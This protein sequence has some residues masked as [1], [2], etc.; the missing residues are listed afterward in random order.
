MEDTLQARVC[1]FLDVRSGLSARVWLDL[2]SDLCRAHTA[3]V[4]VRL[5]GPVSAETDGVPLRLG[6]RKQRAVFALLALQVNSPVAL[7]RLVDELWHDEPPAQATLSLQSYISRLRRTISDTQPEDQSKDQPAPRILTRPPGWV[8]IMPAENVDAVRF[9]DLAREGSAL[10]EGADVASGAAKLREGLALWTG[11]ALADLDDMPFAVAEKARLQDLRVSATESLLWAELDLGRPAEVV[12]MARHAVSENPYREHAWCALMLALYRLGRQSEAL[13]VAHDLREILADGLGLDPSP[14]ARLL[15]EQI[16]TQAPELD[17]RARVPR[18]TPA[19]VGLVETAPEP[20]GPVAAGFVGRRDVCEALDRVVVD[21]TSGRGRFV[22]V[23]GPAGMGKSAVLHQLSVALQASGVLV[24]RGGGVSAGAMPALWPWVSMLRQLVAADR[25]VTEAARTGGSAAALALLDPSVATTPGS[26]GSAS[27]TDPLLARTRLYRAVVDLLGRAHLARPLALLVDDAHWLDPDTLGLLALA[28]DE[29]LPVGVVVAV[30]LR[31]DE[32]PAVS[33]EIDAVAARH[34]ARTMKIALTG[35]R[36][37]DVEQ[38]VRRTNP[39]NTPDD[40]LAPALVARTGGNPFFV[41]ELLRLLTSERSLDVASVETVLPHEVRDVL[42]RRID[43]LPD[44]TRSLLNVVALLNRPAEIP[45]LTGV[46]GLSDESALDDAEAAVASSLLVEDPASGGFLLSHDLVRQTLEELLSA[47]R[48]ARMH[49]RIAEVMQAE[50]QQSKAM[51]P[52][53]VV[54]IARHLVLAES[55]VGANAA[56]PYLIAVADDARSR[57]SFH[58]AEQALRTAL[59][60]AARVSDPARRTVLQFELRT[61]LVLQSNVISGPPG[62]RIFGQDDE[63]IDQGANS[64]AETDPLAWWGA[65]VV[66]FVEGSSGQALELAEQAL[67]RELPDSIKAMVLHVAAI[68]HFATGRFES[69]DQQFGRSEELAEQVRQRSL[70]TADPWLVPLRVSTPTMR[71]MNAVLVEDW[72]GAEAHLNRARDRARSDPNELVVVEHFAGWE[73]AVRGD[74]VT[75]MHHA[76]AALEL[77]QQL[78]DTPYLRLSRIVVGWATAIEGDERGAD[79]ARVA[80]AECKALSL[81]FLA[82]VHLL[83]CAEACAHHG[84][85]QDARALVLESRSMAQLTGEKTVNNRLERVARQILRDAQDR[86]R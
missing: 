13:E 63:P 38:L 70:D 24:L 29:F 32:S 33:D 36:T 73:A 6:S 42:R 31:A 55:V 83:L 76:S 78:G 59:E 58:L 8:L 4:R 61:R 15:Q 28:A 54:E 16:L 17:Q 65:Q 84:N 80:Y 12:E 40:A 46:T 18:L 2:G 26:A 77:G 34:H 43:R 48:L 72:S 35:L 57:A 22:V 39:D 75:A 53:V 50:E 23:D 86:S 60:L 69:A 79:T 67:A 1:T 19:G 85:L 37:A 47:N 20:D 71:S 10:L 66:R 82:A 30:A 81:R 5:L 3:W 44:R 62:S 64:L 25:E 7:D 45:L 74:A 51:L 49:A 27:E 11:D 14:E 52:E 68:C 21:A 9:I 56:I 41:T